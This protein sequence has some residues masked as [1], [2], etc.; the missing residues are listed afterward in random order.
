MNDV[1][2]LN[3]LEQKIVGLLNALKA[4]KEKNLKDNSSIIESQ[5]LSKIEEHVDNMINIIEEFE[6][7]K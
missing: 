2:L 3:E 1:T 4:E 5:K 7:Q 6:S